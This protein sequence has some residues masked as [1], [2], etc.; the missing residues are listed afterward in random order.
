[1]SDALSGLAV[2]A[3]T[4][5]A[6]AGI[7][8]WAG[9]VRRRKI[10]ALR[11]LCLRRGWKYEPL[12]GSLR[13]G[14]R[15]EGD[16]W[17]FEAVSRSS[18]RE[19]GPG[20]SDWDH[21]TLWSS[22]GENPGRGT[23]ILGLNPGGMR[24]LARMPAALLAR[25]L[26][27]EAAGMRPYPAGGRLE[28]RFMLLAREEPPAMG[29]LDGRSEEMLAAWPAALPLVVRSSPARLEL[30]VAGRRLERPEDIERLVELGQSFLQ[31]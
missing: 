6:V 8:L 14:H 30:R 10:E 1:M 3:V 17:S 2:A 13:H 31:G 18:G 27:P 26:G 22:S 20:S 5:V 7:F 9:R 4:A 21:A 29:F 28:P 12:G 16:G 23:F 25:F 11:G 15:I 24:D 19:S